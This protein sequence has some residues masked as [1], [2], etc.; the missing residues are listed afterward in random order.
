M[1]MR[2][3]IYSLDDAFPFIDEE[4]IYFL[5]HL[6]KCV[7]RVMIVC[8]AS[9]EEGE[10]G[11]L[12]ALTDELYLNIGGCAANR[13]KYGIELLLEDGS[14]R[15]GPELVL[16]NDSFFGP[17]YPLRHVFTDMDNR[18]LD[19]W[20]MT[21]EG[22]RLD[23]IT[24]RQE[25]RKRIRFLQPY[26]LCFYG[27]VTAD[28]SFLP[29]W[30]NLPLFYDSAEYEKRFSIALTQY[31]GEKFKWDVY[32]D[33]AMWEAQE[34]ESCVPYSIVWPFELIRQ[35]KLP[36]LSK[37][38]VVI[39]REILLNYQLG[40]Q[41]SF[42]LRYIDEYTEYDSNLI[43]SYLI[44]RYHLYDLKKALNLNY[45]ITDQGEGDEAVFKRNRVA[46]FAHLY[47]EELFDYCLSYL[48]P[49]SSY[50]DIY[51]TTGSERSKGMIEARLPETSGIKKIGVSKYRGREWAAFLLLDRQYMEKYD[52][53]CL[54]HDKKSAQMFYPTVGKS[55]CDNL[56]E[57]CLKNPKYV[58]GILETFEQKEWVGLMVP[59]EVY[60][61]TY[62]YTAIDFWTICF[63]GTKNLLEKLG[64]EVPLD[65]EKPP[66]AVGSAF[67]CR[68]NA[69]KKLIQM[70]IKEED[71]PEEPMP[72]DGSFN[73]CLERAVPY[74]AQQ[75]G[76]YTCSIMTPEYAGIHLA[77]Y[78]E[79]VHRIM[80]C[81]KE[82]NKWNLSTFQSS[83]DSLQHKG[84]FGTQGG[85][86][87]RARLKIYGYLVNR[88]PS[89][90]RKYHSIRLQNPG[91]LGRI[92]AWF[93][94]L[95]MNIGYIFCKGKFEDF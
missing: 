29:F 74:L 41:I 25:E 82:E 23:T 7:D 83:L 43:Y 33:T 28:P 73:H 19:F 35:K 47:Y 69:I 81:L 9:Y 12:E 60:H 52:Y 3:G 31:F 51:I 27:N 91:V 15:N 90:Q 63:H 45:V 42:A 39:D 22:K 18:G 61:G 6:K 87:R 72:V 34:G 11:K 48:L 8:S 70:D 46:V 77:N 94:L 92:Y 67:W 71:F 38:A 56:W 14:L 75:E 37:A 5:E 50:A 64:A 24:G 62:F 21:A 10:L 44:K 88:V 55:F 80:G 16:V 54:I 89:I 30:R 13:W 86:F 20:G 93:S 40:E 49:L 26:F 53:C 84:D 32:A 57:N 58:G 68:C 65:E 76:Y 4:K 59:P 36:V 1:S 2:I 95:G 78:G 66:V 17:L 79:I 85:L